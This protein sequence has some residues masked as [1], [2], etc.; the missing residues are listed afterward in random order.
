[1]FGN[2]RNKSYFIKGKSEL[3]NAKIRMGKAELTSKLKIE[4]H[5]HKNQPSIMPPLVKE[6]A[7]L[8]EK[9]TREHRTLNVQHRIM[10]SVY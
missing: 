5:P 8:I 1:M 9:E 6:T 7:G 2:L 10:Y 3:Q 4:S